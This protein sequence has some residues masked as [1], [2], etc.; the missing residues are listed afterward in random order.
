MLG[1]QRPLNTRQRR[2]PDKARA[3]PAAPARSAPRAAPAGDVTAGTQQRTRP[4]PA[5]RSLASRLPRGPSR[6]TGGDKAAAPG[7]RERKGRGSGGRPAQEW[8]GGG[9]TA[10]APARPSGR[11]AR[12]LPRAPPHPLPPGPA[13]SRCPPRSLRPRPASAPRPLAYL[14]WRRRLL[15]RLSPV[16]VAGSV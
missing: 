4:R 7:T 10:A 8:Q 6:R 16:P 12:R 11:A 13:A 15:I 5:R 14:I 9:R 1:D 3:G 2:R